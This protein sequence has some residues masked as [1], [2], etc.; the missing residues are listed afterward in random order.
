MAVALQAVGA[1]GGLLSALLCGGAYQ[2]LNGVVGL[3]AGGQRGCEPGKDKGQQGVEPAGL[4]G[5]CAKW[6]ASAWGMSAGSYQFR[7]FQQLQVSLCRTF[8]RP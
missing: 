6:A 3:G 7:S 5:V 1:A 2:G 8:S 4:G